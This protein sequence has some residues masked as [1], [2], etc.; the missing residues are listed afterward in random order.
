MEL[1]ELALALLSAYNHFEVGNHN[2]LWLTN[3]AEQD[4]L[5]LTLTKINDAPLLRKYINRN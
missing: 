3:G 1:V 5:M 4:S 2:A